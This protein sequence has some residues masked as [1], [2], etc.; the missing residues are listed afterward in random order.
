MEELISEEAEAGSAPVSRRTQLEFLSH[1]GSL[2][3]GQ[4]H[5]RARRLLSAR[6]SAS[7]WIEVVENAVCLKEPDKF[8]KRYDELKLSLLSN[9]SAPETEPARGGVQGKQRKVA[10]ASITSRRLQLWSP[11]GRTVRLAAIDVGGVPCRA[12]EVH[13]S[14]ANFWRQTFERQHGNFPE[15]KARAFLDSYGVRLGQLPEAASDHR[16]TGLRPPELA[17]YGRALAVAK[18]SAPGPDGL[19]YCAWRRAG[20]ESKRSLQMVEE[21]LRSEGPVPRDFNFSIAAFCPKAPTVTE[22]LTGAIRAAQDTRPLNLKDASNKVVAG[23]VN[24]ELKPLLSVSL[25]PAQRGFVQGRNPSHN[26]IEVDASAREAAMTDPSLDPCTLLFDF[27]AAFPSVSQCFLLFLFRWLGFPE[28]LTKLLSAFYVN[29]RVFSHS[30]TFMY[31]V[32]SGTLQ[33]CPLSGSCFTVVV[34]AFLRQ[35]CSITGA[36]VGG[37]VKACADDIA[38]TLKNLLLVGDLRRAFHAFGGLSLLALKPQKCIIL[39]A[40][41]PADEARAKFVEV[42]KREAPGWEDFQIADVGVYLGCALGRQAGTVRWAACI[43]KYRVRVAAIAN[44]AALVAIVSRLYNSFAFSVLQYLPNFSAPP[45]YLFTLERSSLHKMIRLPQNTLSTSAFFHLP[46]VGL[47]RFQMVGSMCAATAATFFLSFGVELEMWRTRLVQAASEGVEGVHALWLF[48][49]CADPRGND[50]GAGALFLCK[51]L[52]GAR[53]TAACAGGRLVAARG[54]LLKRACR[55]QDFVAEKRP[56][57]QAVQRKSKKFINRSIAQWLYPDI[58]P[59]ILVR[60]VR[61]FAHTEVDLGEARE[62]V[63]IIKSEARRQPRASVA[64]FRWYMNGLATSRRLH[65]AVPRQCMFGCKDQED[66]QLHYFR[67]RRARFMT[68]VCTKR[69][70]MADEARD[71]LGLVGDSAARTERVRQAA[72]ISRAYSTVAGSSV[73]TAEL[74]RACTLAERGRIWAAATTAAAHAIGGRQ[75]A[76]AFKPRE[77]S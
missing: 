15:S 8:S 28:G 35:L 63:G 73:A 61:A 33:G 25:A 44:T 4:R 55:M 21:N 6:P 20:K 77:I 74:Q 51:W 52:H 7:E 10:A 17:A 32:W 34:D 14:L 76:R 16:G 12:E 65:L 71:R 45:P 57:I 30:G 18:S 70:P 50:S 66:S 24:H 68:A 41:L 60:R 27:S 11:F 67:C 1:I 39:P 54:R 36:G 22:Q 31:F 13:N 42:L 59:E 2:V 47:P 26:V 23:V 75:F 9:S 69:L 64:A 62:L 43:D 29:V 46:G 49:G 53:H 40:A 37:E 38:V 48:A 58:L 3:A 56:E 72:T 5:V 19:P